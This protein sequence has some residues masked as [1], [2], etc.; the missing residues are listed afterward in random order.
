LDEKEI[1]SSEVYIY[2]VSIYFHGTHTTAAEVIFVRPKDKMVFFFG[3]K[4]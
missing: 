1:R 4:T 2:P 3:G